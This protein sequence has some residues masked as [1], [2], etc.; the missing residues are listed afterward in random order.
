MSPMTLLPNSIISLTGDAAD[1]LLALDDGDAALA[2]LYLLRHGS[3][4]GLNWPAHRL[5]SA[6]DK[7]AANRLICADAVQA[8]P[9]PAQAPELL[10]P[11]YTTQDLTDALSDGRSDFPALCSEVERRLGKKLSTA[12]LRSLYTIYDHLALPA[13]VILMLVSWCVDATQR[14]YGPGRMPLMSQIQKEGFRWA[15][16]NIDTL[17][18]AEEHITHL[19]RMRTREGEVL[20][21][22]DIPTRPLVER[23]RSYIAAWDQMGFDDEAIRMAYERTVMKKQS[24]NWSYMNGILRGWHAKG[25]HTAAQIRTADTYPRRA[26]QPAAPAPA[27]GPDRQAREDMERMRRLMQQMKQDQQ[28]G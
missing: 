15:R 16:Q 12:D 27:Q 20:R 6:L 14:R 21:L 23:E 26:G 2:Y 11:E 3:P 22:L 9:A 18:R 4:Q 10:P 24:M 25:L 19:T 5:Q 7:L 1:R 13:E 28:G 17:E 8:A